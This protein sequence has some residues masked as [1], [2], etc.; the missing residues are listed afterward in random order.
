MSGG[1]GA[2]IPLLGSV[3]ARGGGAPPPDTVT[4]TLTFG[5]TLEVSGY[6]TR[7]SDT[8]A[9]GSTARPSWG[10]TMLQG[11]G[12][13]DAQITNLATNVS[14]ADQ[15]RLAEILRASR[16][17]TL[18]DTIGLAQTQ[19]IRLATAVIEQLRLQPLLASSMRYRQSVIDMVLMADALRRFIGAGA[20][21]ALVLA[22]LT[23]QRTTK[24]AIVT[25]SMAI[26][27]MLSPRLLI[28]VV[29]SD[30]IDID[31]S[32]VAK[33]LYGA[34]LLDAIE[35]SA[36]YVHPGRVVTTWAMNTRSGAVS[37][38]HNYPFNSFARMGHKYLGATEEGLYELVGDYDEGRDVTAHIKSG[39]VQWAGTRL[40]MFK[41]AYI[42]A[43]GGG[44][45][46]LRV[47]SGDRTYEY[48]VSTTDM[49]STKINIGKGLRARYFSFELISSGQDF[50]LDTLE[51]VPIVTDRRV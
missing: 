11:L 26:S 31:A 29:M 50:E 30:T 37:E 35:F 47:V 20:V 22:E 12:L 9:L 46:V 49:V 21:D 39:L 44:E 51:F 25:E 34:E 15:V 2:S 42:A 33:A 24:G 5:D 10:A 8:V 18:A 43:R 28:K 13:S 16:A 4:D 40:T 1:L 45:Y 38:Y 41:A 3:A 6:G 17:G 32:T 48:L 23:D 36:A 7:I 14:L 19:Q 27:S